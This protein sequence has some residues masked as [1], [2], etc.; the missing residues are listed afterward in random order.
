EFEPTVV[1]DPLGG[2]FAAPSIDA[3][4]ARGRYVSFGTSAGPEVSF[5]MQTLY[6]KALTLYGYGGMQLTTTERRQGLGK[7]LAALSDGRLKL[8]IDGVV[9]L[10]EVNEAFSRIEN[11]EVQGK[12]LLDLGA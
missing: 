6:R 1:F 11:R 7:A 10:A 5:N 8:R 2:G 3:L 12:L 4:T 9:P